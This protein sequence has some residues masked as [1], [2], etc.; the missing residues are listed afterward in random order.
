MIRASDEN[1]WTERDNYNISKRCCDKTDI[2]V[3]DTLQFESLEEWSR[4]TRR[5]GGE[6][7]RICT[8]IWQ[9]MNEIA[10]SVG[11]EAVLVILLT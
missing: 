11:E 2:Q 8:T 5:F 3:I 7:K 1:G 6:E 10:S 9:K 4:Q